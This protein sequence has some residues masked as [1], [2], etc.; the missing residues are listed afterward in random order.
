MPHILLF[1]GYL[2]ICSGKI[3]ENKKEWQYGL[4]LFLKYSNFFILFA[5]SVSVF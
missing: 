1:S 3:V 4:F 5:F 2:S